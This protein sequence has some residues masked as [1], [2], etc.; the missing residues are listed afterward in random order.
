M[1]SLE[2]LAAR[3]RIRSL[4]SAPAQFTA[5]DANSRLTGG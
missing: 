3:A 1:R 4:L 2:L 5:I